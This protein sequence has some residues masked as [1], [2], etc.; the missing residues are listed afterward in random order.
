MIVIVKNGYRLCS[1]NR[2]RSFANFGTYPECVKEYRSLGWAKKKAKKIGGTV[3]E[4]K[5]G[6]TM[7]ACGRI[8]IDSDRATCQVCG[9]HPLKFEKE[10]VVC[11]TYHDTPQGVACTNGGKPVSRMSLVTDIVTELHNNGGVNL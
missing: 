1:D 9:H 7:D 2:W 8:D 11:F 6:E 10:K 3:V 4:L 5:E